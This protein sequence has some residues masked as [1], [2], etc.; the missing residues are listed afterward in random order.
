MTQAV[1][2]VSHASGHDER[3]FPSWQQLSGFARFVLVCPGLSLV[4]PWF[5]CGLY[6]FVRG[7]SVVC[8][9]FSVLVCA[10]CP[11]L[12]RFSWFVPVCPVCLCLSWFV[13]GLSVVCPILSWFVQYVLVCPVFL[14]FFWFARFVFVCP[15][16][17]RVCLWSVRFC[18]GLCDMSWF[19]PFFL[20]CSG[21]PCL[22]LFVLVCPWRFEGGLAAAEN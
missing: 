21:L 20:A 19:V 15:G 2:T 1:T 11:G 3:P 13:P 8:L 12:S 22:S 9:I 17:S 14:G 5:V 7:L 4:R 16:L 10:V 18:P 6:W